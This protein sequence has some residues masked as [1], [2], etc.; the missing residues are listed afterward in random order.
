[1]KAA[2]ILL[3]EVDEEWKTGCAIVIAFC[4]PKISQDDATNDRHYVLR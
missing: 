3:N 2:E 1:V 4:F